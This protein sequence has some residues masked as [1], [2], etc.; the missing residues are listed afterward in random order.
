[1]IK[2]YTGLAS[3]ALLPLILRRF[4]S[5]WRLKDPLQ[6]KGRMPI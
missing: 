4:W 5:L 3:I 1:M 2:E 6:L